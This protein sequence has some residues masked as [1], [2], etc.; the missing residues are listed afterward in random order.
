M[1]AALLSVLAADSDAAMVCGPVP[2][3]ATAFSPGCKSAFI[4]SRQRLD[5][6]QRH[7]RMIASRPAPS[8]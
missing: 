3:P 1:A 6:H 4:T 5:W 7:A 2:V 8:D